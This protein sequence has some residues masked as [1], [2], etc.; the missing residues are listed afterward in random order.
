M[1]T[2]EERKEI[3]QLMKVIVDAD[4]SPKLDLI[5]EELQTL[6]EIK[7]S[8]ESLEQHREDVDTEIA[9]LKAAYRNLSREVAELK[10]AN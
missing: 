4:V 2:Q 9:V 10:E 1:L 8:N 5:L 6:R 3:A 7:A